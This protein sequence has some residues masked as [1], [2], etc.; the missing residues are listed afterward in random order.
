MDG[1]VGSINNAINEILAA[2]LVKFRNNALSSSMM[3]SWE[4]QEKKMIA[5]YQMLLNKIN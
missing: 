4:V 2:D 1:G 3:H 5:D